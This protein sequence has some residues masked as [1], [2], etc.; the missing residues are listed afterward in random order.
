MHSCYT[1]FLL[2]FIRL[3]RA[4]AF[5]LKLCIVL[6]H[7]TPEFSSTS[8][9]LLQQ[10][11]DILMSQKTF[12]MSKDWGFRGMQ[13]ESYIGVPEY[14]ESDIWRLLQFLPRSFFCTLSNTRLLYSSCKYILKSGTLIIVLRFPDL[15]Y[16]RYL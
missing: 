5:L 11:I 2:S 16:L 6:L 15:N 4:P 12:G 7:F 3:Y 13:S 10:N 8:V 1:I 14:P 9:P